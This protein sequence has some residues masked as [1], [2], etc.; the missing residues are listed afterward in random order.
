MQPNHKTSDEYLRKEILT[1]FATDK[2]IASANLRVGVLNAI[3]H[4]A[5]AVDSLAKRDAAEMCARTV[6]GIRGVVNRIESP[7]APNPA[8]TVNL[9]FKKGKGIEK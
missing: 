5:G 9:N 1:A 3:A 6:V 2:R 4:L 8:R 7:D